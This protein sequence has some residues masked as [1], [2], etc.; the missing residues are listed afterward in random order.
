[1]VWGRAPISVALRAIAIAV[2]RPKGRAPFAARHAPMD[3]AGASHVVVVAHEYRAFSS[4]LAPPAGGPPLGLWIVILHISCCLGILVGMRA[5]VVVGEVS[6]C[7]TTSCCA[8]AS[9]S[10]CGRRCDWGAS[11]LLFFV[12][13][14]RRVF[15]LRGFELVAEASWRLVG[16]WAAVSVADALC[17]LLP[18]PSAS[19]TLSAYV[20]GRAAASV[21]E[22]FFLLLY[23]FYRLGVS[24]G[25]RAMVTVVGRQLH[26][27]SRVFRLLSC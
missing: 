10:A 20:P 13:F 14:C 19:A 3:G 7:C 24:V 1:M 2:V 22:A 26:R 5:V 9:C 6:A 21:L 27:G 18:V 4:A 15:G 25:L 12:V 16:V 17:F 8:S 23:V 11:Y